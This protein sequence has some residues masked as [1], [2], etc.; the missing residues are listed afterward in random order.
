MILFGKP[1]AHKL[2]TLALVAFGPVGAYASPSSIPS[3]FSAPEAPATSRFEALPAALDDGDAGGADA[4]VAS[5]KAALP[6]RENIR[7]TL[8]QT[9]ERYGDMTYV[10]YVWAGGAIGSK[11]ACM[12]CRACIEARP[13]LKVERRMKSCGACQQCGVDCS[14]FA[15]RVLSDAGLKYPYI[16][17][18]GMTRSSRTELRKKYNLVDMGNDARKAMAGDLLLFRHHVVMVLDAYGDGMGDII[19]M[20]RS[21]KRKGAGGI[22]VVRGQAL[23]RF[24]GKIIK[25]L[26]HGVLH[27]GEKSP[28]EKQQRRLPSPDEVSRHQLI[29]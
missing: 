29:V 21:V 28:A 27:D 12:Q 25:I 14:H 5:G 10:P 4:A 20:T 8:R 26:R 9:M 6:A 17:T 2:V 7:D 11:E 23:D 18:R 3:T 15:N 16:D 1:A 24:R 13:G 22:E 19:H